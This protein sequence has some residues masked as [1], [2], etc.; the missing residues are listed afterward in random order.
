MARDG[1]GGYSLPQA[2]FVFDTVIDEVAVNSNFSDIATALAGSI[3]K[4]GQTTPTANLPMGTFKLTGLGA[5]SSRTDSVNAG[6]V[7]DGALNWVDGGG[8]ADAITATY[9]PAITTLV[10]GQL[11]CVRATAAVS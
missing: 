4:D 2:A 10:D 7:Q 5:G 3:A 11:C 1:S 8:T 6:Q 9:S